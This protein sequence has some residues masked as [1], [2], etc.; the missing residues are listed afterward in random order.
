MRRR[1]NLLCLV[2]ILI[3]L[4]LVGGYFA[5]IS[6]AKDYISNIIHKNLN[7]QTSIGSVTIGFPLSLQLDKLCLFD[8]GDSIKAQEFFCAERLSITPAILPLF[9]RRLVI[10]ELQIDNPRVALIREENG[11]YNILSL[12]KENNLTKTAG[13]QHKERVGGFL[14]LSALKVRDGSIKYID[15]QI[16][17]EGVELF[18]DNVYINIDRLIF[19]LTPM[20]T[21]VSASLDISGPK[22]EAK[23]TLNLNGW[24]DI[25]KKDM[26]AKFKAD[27]IDIQHIKPYL[28][29]YVASSME[30]GR[31]YFTSDMVAK[32]NDLTA[33]CKLKIEDVEFASE[34]KGVKLFGIP[35]STITDII[36]DERKEMAVNFTIETE[37]DN[38][39][40]KITRIS[41]NLISTG[42]KSAI[43]AGIEKILEKK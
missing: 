21:N 28:K 39:R 14:I 10:K 1:T 2:L 8:K 16:S 34:S 22:G 33:E 24:I 15:R 3:I 27:G 17:K 5:A 43:A 29:D 4:T 7:R 9:S 18:A 25:Y 36:K 38:P 30:S 13:V 20:R 41:G 19:P 32:N 23:G 37:L 26:D 35:V 40:L 11:S 6:K 31:I 42:L 12:I